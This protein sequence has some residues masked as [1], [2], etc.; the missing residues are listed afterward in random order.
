MISLAITVSSPMSYLS[1]RCKMAAAYS[2]ERLWQQYIGAVAEPAA[3]QPSAARRTPVVQ[4]SGHNARRMLAALRSAAV[5]VAALQVVAVE[6]AA[7][8]V[9][10]AA[11]GGRSRG[12]PA[13]ALGTSAGLATPHVA[14][15]VLAELAAR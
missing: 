1:L 7:L 5:E 12:L 9:A 14:A 6:A 3:L 13:A 4:L 11:A 2:A 10:V 8:Q 15:A